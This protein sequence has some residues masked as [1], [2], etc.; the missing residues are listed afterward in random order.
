M[1]RRVMKCAVLLGVVLLVGGC[2]GDGPS[3]E[4]RPTG[5]AS[6]AIC[7]LK[8]DVPHGHFTRFEVAPGSSW[9]A[10]YAVLSNPCSGPIA[11]RGIKVRGPLSPGP[12]LT[13]RTMAILVHGSE[14][15]DA[16]W[17][18]SEIRSGSDIGGLTFKPGDKYQLAAEVELSANAV[19]AQRIPLV[20]L[21]Y[22]VGTSPEHADLGPDIGFCA[23]A[24]PPAKGTPSSAR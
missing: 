1:R 20:S 6:T 24:V 8:F 18:S 2:S 10:T 15:R 14:P 13:G 9:W 22:S 23:C 11:L 5:M 12:S 7:H 16:F 21:E 3:A 17:P 4:R 19:S